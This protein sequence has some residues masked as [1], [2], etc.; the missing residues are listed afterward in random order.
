MG[1]PT[2]LDTLILEGI[3]IT[4]QIFYLNKLMK[5]IDRMIT[6]FVLTLI[7]F[8]ILIKLEKIISEMKLWQPVLL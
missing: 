4:F 5:L 1:I 3:R 7:T 6:E 8:E 2:L